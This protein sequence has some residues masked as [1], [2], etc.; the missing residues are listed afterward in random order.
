MD[1]Y[2]IRRSL[3]RIAFDYFNRSDGSLGVADSGQS[4]ITPANTLSI[5]S[6]AAKCTASTPTYGAS[7]FIDTGTQSHTIEADITMASDGGAGLRVLSP[8][9]SPDQ[10]GWCIWFTSSTAYTYLFSAGGHTGFA[11]VSYSWTSGATKHV[12]VVASQTGSTVQIYVYVDGVL[13]NTI[14]NAGA[15]TGTMTLAGIFVL[16]T[17]GVPAQT[18]DNVVITRT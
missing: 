8:T 15:P 3:G 5:V 13:I 2:M 1:C 11:P 16:L 6:N 17:S 14:T 4:W 12:K 18:I 10:N 9:S 7:S